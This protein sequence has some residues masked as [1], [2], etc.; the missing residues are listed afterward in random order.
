MQ[1]VH[2]TYI[3]SALKFN[4]IALFTV[5][6]LPI[7]SLHAVKT[8]S[9]KKESDPRVMREPT[10]V[11]KCHFWHEQRH[12][13]MEEEEYKWDKNEERKQVLDRK[14]KDERG[15]EKMKGR[16]EERRN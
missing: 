7:P 15:E 8:W 4:N 1:F 2:E 16:K 6:W 13:R 9:Q 12:W 14:E 11:L 5:M 3:V 10:A